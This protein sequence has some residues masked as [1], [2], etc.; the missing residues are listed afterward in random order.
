MVLHEIFGQAT[1]A[2]AASGR[3]FGVILHQWHAEYVCWACQHNHSSAA[4]AI[5]CSAT[6]QRLMRILNA[7]SAGA[8]ILLIVFFAIETH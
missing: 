7:L 5:S 6:H 8:V 4:A 1:Y 2:R 3:L